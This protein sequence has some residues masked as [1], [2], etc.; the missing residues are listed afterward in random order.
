MIPCPRVG[1]MSTGDELVEPGEQIS[2][3]F[4]RDS[5]RWSLLFPFLFLLNNTFFLQLVFR[6]SLAARMEKFIPMHIP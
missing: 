6:N 3:G 4:I 1:V 5:N 2:G